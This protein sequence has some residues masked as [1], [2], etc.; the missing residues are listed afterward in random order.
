[1]NYRY[2]VEEIFFSKATCGLEQICAIFVLIATV[3]RRL[4]L[5]YNEKIVGTSI[6]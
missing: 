1:M 2:Q 3:R 4:S 6:S 5:S